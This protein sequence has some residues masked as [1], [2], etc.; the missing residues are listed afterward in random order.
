VG[1]PT[2]HLARTTEGVVAYGG[3]PSSSIIFVHR[4]LL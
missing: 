1:S 4:R 3:A 2:V